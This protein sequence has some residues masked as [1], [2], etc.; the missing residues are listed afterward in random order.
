[1][2]KGCIAP[3]KRK[4]K[5]EALQT[6][7]PMDEVQQ[8]PIPPTYPNFASLSPSSYFCYQ[9]PPFSVPYQLTF[10]K[11]NISICIGCHNRYP[12]SPQPPQDLRIKH[13][14]W[15]EFVPQGAQTP[16]SNFPTYT[17]TVCLSVSG[18]S[19]PNEFA[20]SSCNQNIRVTFKITL[21]FNFL[22]N[23]IVHYYYQGRQSLIC[24]DHPEK[25]WPPI[26]LQCFQP[27][28]MTARS[29]F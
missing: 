7:I 24:R 14:E 25:K 13:Q 5:K 6:R 21:D 10:I 4:Q 19:L 2:C 26:H 28:Q 15:R 17:I 11:G 18:Y 20:C 22:L 12:K 16:Q 9:S 23:N 1:M 27:A 3:C 29:A 8:P